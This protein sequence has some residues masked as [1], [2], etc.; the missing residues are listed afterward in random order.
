MERILYKNKIKVIFV[1]VLGIVVDVIFKVLEG[2]SEVRIYLIGKV[3]FFIY[4]FMED[5]YIEL[6]YLVIVV[7]NCFKI[8]SCGFSNLF[9]CLVV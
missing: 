3:Y 4:I 1:L 5:G 6:G 9:I 7:E 2:K 8:Y